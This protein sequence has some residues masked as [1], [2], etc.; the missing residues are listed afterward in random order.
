MHRAAPEIDM[1]LKLILSSGASHIVKGYSAHI[2]LPAL[3]SWLYL[4]RGETRLI[5]TRLAWLRRRNLSSRAS[6]ISAS[7]PVVSVTSYGAR[8]ESVHLALESIAAGSLLPSRLILWVDSAEALA[9]PSARLKRLAER[10]LEIRLSDNYGPHTKYYPY[11]L[12]MDT[13]DVPLATA[14][15]DQIYSKWW[16][17]GLVRSHDRFPNAVNCYRAHVMRVVGGVI[18][19]Y[20]SWDPCTSTKP[21]LL[22]FATG[23]SGAI[24]PPSFLRRLKDAGSGFTHVCPKADDTWLHANALRAGVK[25]RQ[26]WERQLRFPFSPGTQGMGLYHSNVL[27]DQNDDQIRMTYTRDD[28]ARLASATYE[29]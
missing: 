23:V 26:V 5:G 25:T 11:L 22:H 24:Y 1:A 19:P 15:D 17:E 9:N 28:L 4:Q 3:Q 12:S 16:L 7:G 21:S 18:A 29:P 13:F 8:L 2:T 6:V 20:R 14:D 10:G 27:L